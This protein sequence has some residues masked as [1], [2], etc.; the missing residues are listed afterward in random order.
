MAPTT[1]D[2]FEGD[3][4]SNNLFSDLAPLLTLFGEQVTKQFLSMSMG[5]ADNFLLA[6][7]PL[8][9][10]T[11]IVS[12]IRVG[13]GKRL[14]ALIGR[15]RESHSVAEQELLSSTS[16]NVCEMWNGQQIV[17]L[18]GSGEDMETFLITRDG[19]VSDLRTAAKSYLVWSYHPHVDAEQFLSR[20]NGSPNLTLN[21]QGATASTL[22]LWT[23]ALLGLVF[24][25]FSITFAG[26]ATYHLKWKKGK[27]QVAEYGYPCFCAGTTCLAIAIVACGHVIESVTDER[28]WDLP[29]GSRVLTLQKARTV[30]DQHFPSCAISMTGDGGSL[31]FS[32]L[33][34]KNY[35]LFVTISTSLAILGYIVQ[36]IGLRA[37]HWSVTIAQLG[38]TLLMTAVRSW[39]RRGLASN[40]DWYPL[41]KDF[42]LASLSLV[43][44]Y[45]QRNLSTASRLQ[46]HIKM[47]REPLY[48]LLFLY[49]PNAV[50]FYESELLYPDVPLQTSL[51]FQDSGGHEEHT[52]PLRTF[53]RISKGIPLSSI[54]KEASALSNM[55]S[56]VIRNVMDVLDVSGVLLWKGEAPRQPSDQVVTDTISWVF[57]FSTFQLPED[58]N[59][60]PRKVSF[61]LQRS[62]DHVEHRWTLLNHDQIAA[63]L[64]LSAQALAR[65]LEHLHHV[66]G[67]ERLSI[68]DRLFHVDY[69][70]PYHPSSSGRIVGNLNNDDS[71]S[72]QEMLEEW[73]DAE[74][75]LGTSRFRL[76]TELECYLGIFLTSLPGLVIQTRLDSGLLLQWT[77]ELFS[78]FM[79]AVASKVERI[80][81]E[82]K[83]VEGKRGEG[84]R[85]F[86]NSVF[87]TIA[88]VVVKEGLVHDRDEAYT[89]I[90]PA[91]AKYD[92][93]PTCGN[94]QA[95][96]STSERPTSP[97]PSHH[98]ENT[99]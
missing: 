34:Q 55:F 11:T 1:S 58:S 28:T 15:A 24:Q 6:M 26:M 9:I 14:K 7:G 35:R 2:E 75:R 17:R 54:D 31:K 81:G 82:T 99:P 59:P 92:L 71:S 88:D 13:G 3:D 90:V 73:L 76:T 80:L 47:A 51:D 68:G 56:T 66:R 60:M 16:Q 72:S 40:P 43:I 63:L 84:K 36:F 22:E 45:G 20:K 50:D 96:E 8:G 42:E 4:F 65:R 37:L 89:L 5:W 12:A 94:E 70:V 44:H 62:T 19:V 77:Q 21:V 41:I 53:S 79:L 33:N 49:L 32:R 95:A 64:A 39:A 85:C 98:K 83:E 48:E 18:I 87:D 61:R 69:H 23:W 29:E 57:N 25:L 97:A 30:G 78:I 52:A 10:I 74:I 91:F 93:L 27:A 86:K 46:K 67:G 38:I